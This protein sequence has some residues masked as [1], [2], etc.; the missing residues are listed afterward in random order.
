MVISPTSGRI[1]VAEIGVSD[2]NIALHCRNFPLKKT[3]VN[4]RRVTVLVVKSIGIKPVICMLYANR[5]CKVAAAFAHSGNT[6][7]QRNFLR[8]ER[9]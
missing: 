2:R 3:P 1:L 8:Q 9:G 4:G 5:R 7:N 6:F